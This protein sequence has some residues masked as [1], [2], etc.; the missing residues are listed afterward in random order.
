MQIIPLNAAQSP[1]RAVPSS[2]LQ[3]LELSPAPSSAA[4]SL[5]ER[6]LSSVYDPN[7]EEEATQKPTQ[8]VDNRGTV[9]LVASPSQAVDN[10]YS[11]LSW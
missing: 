8:T 11:K 7:Q 10:R 6:G 1:A 5:M 9:S 2:A 4:Q 3:V